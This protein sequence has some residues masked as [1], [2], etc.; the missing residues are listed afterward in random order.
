MRDSVLSINNLSG[1]RID[2]IDI[3]DNEQLNPNCD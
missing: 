1:E 2:V 3:T